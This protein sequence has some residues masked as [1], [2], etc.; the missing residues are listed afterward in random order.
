MTRD[1][2]IAV[3]KNL[4]VI[5]AIAEG[6][7]VYFAAFD[8]K[9]KFIR[10]HATDKIGLTQIRSCGYSVKPRYQCIKPGQYK[11]I[12]YPHQQARHDK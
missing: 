7:Q 11:A 12:P 2:C 5:Q 6:K 9:G 3:L 8:Y 1:D 4:P 10:W